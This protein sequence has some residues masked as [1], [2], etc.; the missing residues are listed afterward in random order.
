MTGFSG[1]F[2]QRGVSQA[3]ALDLQIV[4]DINVTVK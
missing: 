1:V 4:A 3:E 2:G